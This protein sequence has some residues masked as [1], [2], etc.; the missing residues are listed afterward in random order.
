MRNRPILLPRI[1]RRKQAIMNTISDFLQTTRN[2]LGE[3]LLVE[4]LVGQFM[5]TDEYSG[6]TEVGDTVDFAF[7]IKLLVRT[8][9]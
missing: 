3:P 5:G 4:N 1:V 2:H 6:D 7:W 8:I 9:K